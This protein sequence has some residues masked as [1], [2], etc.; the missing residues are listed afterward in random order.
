L[1][2]EGRKDPAKKP[3]DDSGK[4]GKAKGRGRKAATVRID[5]DVK[6]FAEIMEDPSLARLSSFWA[7]LRARCC[8]P[9]PS[10]SMSRL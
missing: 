10:L 1:K 4:A 3:R 6:V 7:R 8:G 2:K 9:L 5:D